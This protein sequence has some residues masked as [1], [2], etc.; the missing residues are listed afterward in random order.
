MKTLLLAAI[1]ALNVTA[2]ATVQHGPVQRIH[3]ESEPSGAEV[4]TTLC[5][6]GSTKKALTPAVIWVSR[7]AERCTLLF[8]ADGYESDRVVLTRAVADESL[9]NL[10][11]FEICAEDVLDCDDAW[12][13]FFFGGLLAGTGFGVDAVTGALFEQQ[14]ADVFVRLQPLEGPLP[15]P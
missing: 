3:V 13:F 6:P 11:F 9:D 7:R 4:L 15:D 10:E 1:V 12:P 8:S 14:P 2:C 5:G